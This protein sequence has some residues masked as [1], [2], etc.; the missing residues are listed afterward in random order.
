MTA[1]DQTRTATFMP[2]FTTMFVIALLIELKQYKQ[3]GLRIV[4][5]D[6]HIRN[7]HSQLL[8]DYLDFVRIDLQAYLSSRCS[9]GEMCN[10]VVSNKWKSVFHSGSR[11]VI[12]LVTR[13]L[14]NF[15]LMTG[16]EG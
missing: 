3:S 4:G 1:G 16:Q 7:L 2:F 5:Q 11:A 13:I 12:K 15:H 9:D 8:T 10:A 6:L 14:Q